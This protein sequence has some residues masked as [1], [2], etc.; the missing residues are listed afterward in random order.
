ME[1][2]SQIEYFY[3]SPWKEDVCLHFPEP[4][5]TGE[6]ADE[7]TGQDKGPDLRGS[8]FL[9]GFLVEVRGASQSGG[10]G[11]IVPPLSVTAMAPALL[12]GK[13]ALQK[14]HVFVFVFVFFSQSRS[15]QKQGKRQ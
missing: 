14:A 5:F 9:E 12:L 8:G 10:H 6:T 2:L 15:L 3:S 7:P 13:T 1:V 4:C 11:T